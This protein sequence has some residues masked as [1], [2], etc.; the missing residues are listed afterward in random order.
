MRTRE[1][2]GKKVSPYAAS[3]GFIFASTL[4]GELV[5]SRLEPTNLAMLYLLAV[6][7]TAA[8]WGKGPAVATAILSVLAFDFFLVPPYLAFSVA[9]VQYVFTFAGLLAA[10]LVIG[11]LTSRMREQAIRSRR[12]E[13]QTAALYRFSADLADAVG[14]EAVLQAIRKNVEEIT[15]CRAAIYL[16]AGGVLELRS[17]DPGFPADEREKRIARVAFENARPAAGGSDEQTRRRTRYF[18]LKTAHGVMGVLGI[19]LHRGMDSLAADEEGLVNALVTQAAAAIQRASLA[20]ESRHVEIMRQTEKLQTALLSS[21]SHDLRTPLVSITGTLTSLQEN[22]PGLDDATRKELLENA[23][24]EAD[25]LNRIVGNLL[26]LTRLEAGT[27]RIAKRPCDLRDVLGASLEQLRERIG[28]RPV[29]IAIPRDFP[30]VPMD[31]SFMMKAFFN[32]LD[33]AVKYSPEDSPIDIGARVHRNLAEMEIRNRGAGIPEGDLEHI[34]EKFYR[35]EKPQ[36][37]TGTGLGLSICKGI[38]E[39]HGGRIVAR[40]NTDSG[41]TFIVTLPLQETRGEQ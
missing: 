23:M 11:T 8:R 32:L 36:R 41:A 2:I 22:S 21:I 27:L 31:F 19:W 9:D 38:I 4:I 5:K 1:I 6:V 34:F 17:G 12:Q 29:R 24:S 30:E 37:V 18:P 7:I 33:N 14:F 26:D 13:A 28:D 35:A 16:P 10:G 39:A 3:I 40:N 20:E 25:R 15:D